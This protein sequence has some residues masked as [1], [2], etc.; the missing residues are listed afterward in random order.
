MVVTGVELIAL[1]SLLVGAVSAINSTDARKRARKERQARAR[2]KVYGE[3]DE[4]EE[5][6]TDLGP[7]AVGWKVESR[8]R[9]RGR[10]EYR[11]ESRS[12]NR[13]RS[14]SRPMRRLRSRSMPRPGSSSIHVYNEERSSFGPLNRVDTQGWCRESY[15]DERGG[16][17]SRRL[18]AN[19]RTSL[20]TYPLKS[21]YREHSQSRSCSRSR[22]RSRSRRPKSRGRRSDSKKI[23]QGGIGLALM[24]AAVIGI[25]QHG[26]NRRDQHTER[27]REPFD[28]YRNSDRRRG[29]DW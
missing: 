8:E 27:R 20:G 19:R 4:L 3:N 7:G 14:R 24:G 18:Y 11:E 25:A 9:A 23:L 5:D 26:S 17:S 13:S 10:G 1:G 12:R 28:G 21:R 6:E 2:T 29:S 15:E 22:S 16:I